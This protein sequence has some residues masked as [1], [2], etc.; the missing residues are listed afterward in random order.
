MT[1][2]CEWPGIQREAG[3]KDLYD[4]LHLKGY[5]SVHVASACSLSVV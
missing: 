1:D 5:L 3:Q 2:V 4:L